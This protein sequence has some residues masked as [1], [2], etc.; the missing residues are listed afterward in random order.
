MYHSGLDVTGVLIARASG[1]SFG[2]FLR[3]R[4]FEPL[5]MK[6]TGF[7]VPPDKINRF[8]TS[9]GTARRGDGVVVFDDPIN[10]VY[11]E[12]PPFESGASG[13]VS[14]AD[15]LLAFHRML[16]AK[17]ANLLSPESVALMTSVAITP[18]QRATGR[19]FLDKN[20]SW[21]LG[22]TVVSARNALSM[23]AGTFGWEGGYGTTA[24]ADPS[25]DLVGILL[26]T[27]L[28]DPPATPPW[29]TDFWILTYQAIA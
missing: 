1:K 19:N 16:V 11:R 22:L 21:G 9:Y 27:R 29:F 2:D 20:S 17:G 18:E 12:P 24:Y 10:G 5:G 8:M 23:N 6:D 15:D 28:L 14:T 3:E 7:F 26:T 13:L 25:E 4:I